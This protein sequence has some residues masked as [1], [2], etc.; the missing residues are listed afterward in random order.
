MFKPDDSSVYFSFETCD[1]TSA[2]L[3]KGFSLTDDGSEYELRLRYGK[4]DALTSQIEFINEIDNYFGTAGSIAVF[5][6]RD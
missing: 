2:S 6:S 3:C 4:M 5:P 1:Q